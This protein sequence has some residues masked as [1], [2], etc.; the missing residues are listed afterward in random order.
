M[1]PRGGGN[2]A[3][4]ASRQGGPYRVLEAERLV[5]DATGRRRLHHHLL[6]EPVDQRPHEADLD[7]RHERDP[8]G[9]EAGG[10]ERGPEGNPRGGGGGARR[11][12][13]RTP[14][15]PPP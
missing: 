12:G 4:R 2:A 13:G 5:V 8:V 14:R 6:L 10:G 15:A 7:G 3:A 9:G 11:G 1:R